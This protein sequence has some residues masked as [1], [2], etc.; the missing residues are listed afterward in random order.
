[1]NK[2]QNELQREY[3]RKDEWVWQRVDHHSSPAYLLISK[4][5]VTFYPSLFRFLHILSCHAASLSLSPSPSPSCLSVA[6]FIVP[7]SNH[8]VKRKINTHSQWHVPAGNMSSGGWIKVNK[9]FNEKNE[10]RQM[11]LT[12]MEQ[13]TGRDNGRKKISVSTSAFLV[14]FD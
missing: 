9:G 1:M 10:R 14:N 12:N 3:R 5:L 6:V 11:K 13:H 4:S 2:R 7:C 8:T